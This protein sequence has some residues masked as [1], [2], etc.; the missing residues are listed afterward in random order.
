MNLVLEYI[1]IKKVNKFIQD[2]ESYLIVIFLADIKCCYIDVTR[3]HA[4]QMQR[5]C[6]LKCKN[7][8]QVK[9]VVT[10]VQFEMWCCI[11][12]SCSVVQ[13]VIECAS[14]R[15]SG[16][17][18]SRR[19]MADNIIRTGSYTQAAAKRYRS[20][21]FYFHSDCI[22]HV[23]IVLFLSLLSAIIV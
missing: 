17:V 15:M 8:C 4:I 13:V 18:C 7:N 23:I 11:K 16:C 5:L 2:T 12:Y 10:K 9:S 22:L 19:I 3:D 20:I 14:C 21:L 1:S 6:C